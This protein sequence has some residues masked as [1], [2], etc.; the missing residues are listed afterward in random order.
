VYT[1]RLDS[2]YAES[3]WNFTNYINI[4]L[5]NVIKAELLSC[6]FYG[7]AVSIGSTAVYVHIDELVSKFMDRGNLAYTLRVGGKISTEGPGPASTISNTN[8]LSAALV[9]IPICDGLPDQQ[10]VFTSGNYFP[11]EV[12]FIEPIR[13]IEKLTV[14]LYTADGS[15][16]E[17]LSVTPTFITMRFTCSKPNRCV[18][19][20][21]GGVPLL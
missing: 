5:R 1:V 17:N 4:P 12:S 8:K 20:D 15:Q 18:Y 6:A 13:Q 21:R 19:P 11:V 3:G 7:N 10:T 9:C 2:L 14:S 16:P